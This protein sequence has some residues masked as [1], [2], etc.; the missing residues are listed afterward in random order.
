M[1]TPLID[2]VSWWPTWAHFEVSSAVWELASVS[3]AWVSAGAGATGEAPVPPVKAVPV[4]QSVPMVS[5]TPGPVPASTAVAGRP[6][7]V[8]T[9]RASASRPGA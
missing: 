3:A 2:T 8:A 5:V 1:P 4:V 9:S 7:E 6:I